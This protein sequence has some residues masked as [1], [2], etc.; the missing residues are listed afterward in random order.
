M[1][2]DDRRTAERD[3]ETVWTDEDRDYYRRHGITKRDHMQHHDVLTQQIRK[4]RR[5]A[6]FW[7]ALLKDNAKRAVSA[8]FWFAMLAIALG[9]SGAWEHVAEYLRP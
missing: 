2:V 4:N 6:E 8:V 3:D 5:W 1:A 7:E 9:L